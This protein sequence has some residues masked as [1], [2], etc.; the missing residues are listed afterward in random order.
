MDVKNHLLLKK[1]DQ[2]LNGHITNGETGS[3][4]KI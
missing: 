4:L 1:L 2:N 3:G